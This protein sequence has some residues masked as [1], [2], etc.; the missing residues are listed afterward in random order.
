MEFL[1]DEHTWLV[2]SFL[3]FL[4]ILWSFGKDALLS[5]LDGRIADIQK[6][7][8]TSESLRIEAQE[9]LAQYQRK[10]RDAIQDAE[11]IIADA[12]TGAEASRKQA[13]ADLAKSLERREAQIKER[14]KRMEQSAIHEIQSYAADLAM[15]AATEIITD[16]LDKKTSEKLVEQSIKGLSTQMH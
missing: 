5:A 15:K 10:H 14:I 1:S 9:L 2:I 12:R 6:E 11:K 8:Q 4:G 3:A 13:E 7:L 16:K